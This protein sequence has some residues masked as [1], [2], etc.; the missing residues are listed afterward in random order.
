MKSAKAVKKIRLELF[1]SRAELATLLGISAQSIFHYE[2]EL[3]EPKLHIVK[4]LLD[5]AKKNKI[6]VT[7]SDFFE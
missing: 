6:N 7:S 5:I 3:R 2:T 1:K 4:K